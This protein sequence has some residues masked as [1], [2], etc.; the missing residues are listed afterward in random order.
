MDPTEAGKGVT[1]SSLLPVS[2]LKGTHVVQSEREGT[3][4]GSLDKRPP[5]ALNPLTIKHLGCRFRS[6]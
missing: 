4:P 1:A 2:L 6:F 5:P 3:C